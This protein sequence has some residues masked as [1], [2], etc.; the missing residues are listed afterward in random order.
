MVN[1]PTPPPLLQLELVLGALPTHPQDQ[2]R[3][4]SFPPKHHNCSPSS[5]RSA[6][7]GARV[8]Y[9]IE[10]QKTLQ[11]TERLSPRNGESE[12]KNMGVCGKRDSQTVYPA[13]FGIYIVRPLQKPRPAIGRGP[14]GD[15]HH[16]VMQAYLSRDLRR[17]RSE[18][19]TVR[20][21]QGKKKAYESCFAHTSQAAQMPPTSV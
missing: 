16:T 13:I 18:N 4:C 7:R 3:F 20:R 9:R 10:L 12:R 5:I 21:K 1:H 17:V 11:G 14:P 2:A 8:I 6:V 15:V 19:P